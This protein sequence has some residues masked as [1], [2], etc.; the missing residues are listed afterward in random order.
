MY[1]GL[2]ERFASSK[3]DYLSYRFA[4][5][6]NARNNPVRSQKIVKL[7][8]AQNLIASLVAAVC[9]SV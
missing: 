7:G 5:G 8:V 9:K 4:I 1:P 6:E 3:L 2:L